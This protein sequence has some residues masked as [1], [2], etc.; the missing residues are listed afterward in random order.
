MCVHP[1]RP[2]IGPADR[3]NSPTWTFAADRSSSTSAPVLVP[4]ERACRTQRHANLRGA[5]LLPR[6]KDIN[7]TKCV[8]C[9][10][11][12]HHQGPQVVT[13]LYLRY[14]TYLTGMVTQRNAPHQEGKRR[15]GLKRQK[16]AV[17]V[18]S[19]CP[20]FQVHVNVPCIQIRASASLAVPV[21]VTVTATA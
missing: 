1:T 11:S 4:L 19:P 5:G 3:Q 8:S 17:H 12:S 20:F 10:R 18:P 9:R 7:I 21:T 16:G 14:S 13:Y 6:H 2:V 15:E